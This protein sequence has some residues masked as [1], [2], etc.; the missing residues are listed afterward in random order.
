M[1]RTTTQRGFGLFEFTDD[2]GEACTLQESS[3]ALEPKIWLGVKG[4][5]LRLTPGL[6]WSEVKLP[7]DAMVI[8]RMH[9]TR[10]GVAALLPMLQRFVDDG[11][12]DLEE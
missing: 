5:V 10:D 12:E 4:R 3:S 6:G 7:E 8:D 9:L 11:M 1:K 2:N